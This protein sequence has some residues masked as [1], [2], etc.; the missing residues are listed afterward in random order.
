MALAGSLVFIVLYDVSTV[1]PMT[2]VQLL[3]AGGV[4][5]AVLGMT[6]AGAAADGQPPQRGLRRPSCSAPS[7][8]RRGQRYAYRRARQAYAVLIA[9]L[10]VGVAANLLG[11]T[12]GPLCRPGLAAA[13][14]RALARLH[15]DRPRGLGRG[16]HGGRP[17]AGGSSGAAVQADPPKPTAGVETRR[18]YRPLAAC[19]AGLLGQASRRPAGR[20]RGGARRG[21]RA[22]RRCRTGPGSGAS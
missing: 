17:R 10:V 12:G 19:A 8:W 3:G 18:G 9:A 6:L 20:A 4:I 13:G 22:R 5:L 7:W 21:R 1:R 11:R 16:G 2:T 14:P 15:G